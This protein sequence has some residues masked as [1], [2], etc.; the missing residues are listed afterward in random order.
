MGER[1]VRNVEVEGSS[2]SI[3]TIPEKETV[4]SKLAT[5]QSQ[6][7]LLYRQK[8]GSRKLL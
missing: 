5:K 7:S 3:S 2:P 1:H 8:R 6:V 4:R